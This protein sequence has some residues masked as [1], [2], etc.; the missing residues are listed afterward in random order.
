VDAYERVLA[1]DPEDLDAHY[2]LNQ[3]YERL[4]HGAAVAGKTGRF[5]SGTI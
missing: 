3:C 4:G 5:Q 1:I 2:G